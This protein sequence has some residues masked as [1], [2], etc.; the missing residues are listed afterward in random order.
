M[1]M[2]TCL[3]VTGGIFA[4]IGLTHLLRR[5]VEGAGV[6]AH[7]AGFIAANGAIFVVGSALATWAAMLLRRS[8][9]EPS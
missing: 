8:R 9:R 4:L 7:D 3:L 6:F 1:R 5:F 2:K